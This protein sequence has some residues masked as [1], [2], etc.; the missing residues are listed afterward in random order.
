MA[1]MPSPMPQGAPPGAPGQA[2][3]PGGTGPATV[4]TSMPGMG[5]QGMAGVKTALQMLQKSVA[6]LPMGTPMHTKVL[7]F[8]A[9]VSKDM[10]DEAQGGDDVRQQIAKMARQGPNPDAQAAMQKLV[11][12]QQ[13]P[14]GAPPMGAA[15]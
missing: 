10:G 5:A 14:G 6:E 9:D 12:A 11:G 1:L 2:G 3:P 4:P 15:A 8:I 7:K 13:G